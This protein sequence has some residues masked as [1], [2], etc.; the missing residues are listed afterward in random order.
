MVLRGLHDGDETGQDIWNQP[1][2]TVKIDEFIKFMLL[3]DKVQLKHI[4]DQSGIALGYAYDVLW[5]VFF[6][7]D[8]TFPFSDVEDMELMKRGELI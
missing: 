6:N 3:C 7:A 2:D 1:L 8:I 5:I 4:I